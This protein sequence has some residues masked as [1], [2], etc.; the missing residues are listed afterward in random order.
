M[1]TSP[2]PTRFQPH[3]SDFRVEMAPNQILKIVPNEPIF[4]ACQHLTFS[5][6]AQ[7]PPTHH[8]FCAPAAP[9][10]SH[11]KIVQTKPISP[12]GKIVTTSCES[13]YYEETT[14]DLKWLCPQNQTHFFS[15]ANRGDS[16]LSVRRPVCPITGDFL[17]RRVER[18][19][20]TFGPSIQ[21]GPAFG[22]DS[23][24][25]KTSPSPAHA[26]KAEHH[27]YSTSP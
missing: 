16:A 15:A 13:D 12:R 17:D 14:V 23:S 20:D 7:T 27:E 5:K 21:H 1:K 18:S 3:Q 22:P 11:I 8:R 9:C 26:G 4:I 25:V 6:P 24:L 2:Q 19:R 10:A